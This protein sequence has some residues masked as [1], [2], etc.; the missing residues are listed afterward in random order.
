[1]PRSLPRAAAA[2]AAC[3]EAGIV[4][5]LQRGVERREVVAAVVLQRDRRLVREGVG[6]DEVAAADLDAVDAGVVRDGD[7][8]AAPAGR[9]LPAGRRRDRRRPARC[10]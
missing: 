4:G 10:W 7:R 6:R 5:R 8:P 2:R 1:M 9:S 3:F